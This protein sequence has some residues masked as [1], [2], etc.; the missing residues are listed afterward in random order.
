MLL[1]NNKDLNK[2]TV[3]NPYELAL[4][5]LG[6]L[7]IFHA[8]CVELRGNTYLYNG[9][10]IVTLSPVGRI[11]LI[12]LISPVFPDYLLLQVEKCIAPPQLN[13]GQ[14]ID[15]FNFRIGRNCQEEFEK[16]LDH[17]KSVNEQHVFRERYVE[18]IK[19]LVGSDDCEGNGS[20][21]V[22]CQNILINTE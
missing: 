1:F 17:I 7:L 19:R 6:N 22:E 4:Y 5:K 12:E 8:G 14:S 2:M 11:M 3:K 9:Q 20:D 16:I 13:F 21:L 10:P 18:Y 15:T